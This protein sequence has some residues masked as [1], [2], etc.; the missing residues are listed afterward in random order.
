M[1]AFLFL[2]RRECHRFMKVMVQTIFT[3]VMSASL[4]LLIFGMSFGG[5][6]ELLG[7]KYMA[8]VIPGLMMMGLMNNAF[9]NSSSSLVSSKF[10]GDIEDLAIVPITR[11][12]IVW[13]LSLSS[14]VRGCMVAVITFITGE[15]FYF[16]QN[17]ELLPIAHPIWLLFFLVVGGLVFGQMGLMAAFWAKTFDQL[18]AV[19]AF[20]ILPLTYLG[21]VFTSVSQ[22]PEFWQKVS[23]ANPLLY[24]I[25]GVRFSVLGQAD[26]NVWMSAGISILALVVIFFMAVRV[27]SKVTFSRW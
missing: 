15:V 6:F 25:N 18:S 4:Y 11:G 1:T 21:G 13:A 2:F 7:V 22:L 17:Q 20:V 9:Q 24:F 26:V 3:P 27:L 5:S 19:S 14:V 10:T 8:Y 16:I 12:Q 23:L